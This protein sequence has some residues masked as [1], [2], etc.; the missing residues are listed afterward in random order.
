LQSIAIS[1]PTVARLERWRVKPGQ[2]VNPTDS[3]GLLRTSAGKELRLYPPNGGRIVRL[4]V[5]DGSA[6]KLGDAVCELEPC[7]HSIVMKDLCAEC[8][9]NLR[10]ENGAPGERRQSAL[11]TVAMVHCIPEL[12]VSQGRAECLAAEDEDLLLKQ[13]KL[14]LLVDLDQTVIHT[15]TQNVPPKLAKVHHFQLKPP[16]WYHTR[17]RPG[18][19]EFLARISS[20]YELH[21][22]SFGNRPYAHKIASLIDPEKRYFS[23]RILS[24]DECY[25]P[26]TKTANLK[27]LFPR[28]DHMIVIIDD[29]DEVW[30]S[31][32]SLI[33]VKPYQFFEGTE[34]INCPPGSAVPASKADPMDLVEKAMEHQHPQPEKQQEQQPQDPNQPIEWPDND[35]YL[36][37]L[38][39]ILTDIHSEYYRRLD[40]STGAD[41]GG[42]GDSATAATASTKAKP[43][44]SRQVCTELRGQ[45]LRGCRLVFSGLFPTSLPPEKSKAY[46]IATGLGAE[47]QA[48]VQLGSKVAQDSRT[49]HLVAAKSGTSKF[50]RARKAQSESP[51]GCSIVNPEWLWTCYYEWRRCPEADFPVV[52]DVDYLGLRR[53][54][55]QRRDSEVKRY[56]SD[57]KRRRQESLVVTPEEATAKEDGDEETE[58]SGAATAATTA[59]SVS[60]E[61]PPAAPPAASS[62]GGGSSQQRRF[63]LADNPLLSMS[64]SDLR[65][66]QDEVDAELEGISSSSSSS[67]SS[68]ESEARLRRKVL[69]F[70]SGEASGKSVASGGS[71]GTSKRKLAKKMKELKRRGGDG[72]RA[73]AAA[74]D[75]TD[76]EEDEEESGG[77]MENGAGAAAAPGEDRDWG[78]GCK[79]GYDYADAEANFHVL[80]GDVDSS[81]DE[82]EDQDDE[83]DDEDDEADSIEAGERRRR[84][85]EWRR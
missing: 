31:M 82:G 46:Q 4:L 61:A 18:V 10:T 15:T 55:R 70:S 51:D 83:D 22:I 66:L 53:D 40:A 81:T 62:S 7:E 1:D 23:H 28:G 72:K 29:R 84:K 67:S 12:H 60:K 52:A 50:H 19:E 16:V 33:H 71:G 79:E 47:V 73:A 68:S 36:Y 39:D 14:V 54:S 59:L 6:V 38:A 49:T 37:R 76:D 74:A 35:R 2:Y 8:G 58:N 20:L 45:V 43:P 80:G 69:R 27:S 42:G 75:S 3:L 78:E 5:S 11:A 9:Q 26:L 25:N 21:I 65:S 48:D 85:R 57:R 13:R 41:G 63:E 34:D 44:E 17:V 64:P 56:K 30:D 77:S 32:P 24:R